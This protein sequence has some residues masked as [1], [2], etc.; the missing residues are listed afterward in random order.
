MIPCFALIIHSYHQCDP[1]H[2]LCSDQG[3]YTDASNLLQDVVSIREKSLGLDH[4]S[5]S[6]VTFEE[7]SVVPLEQYVF[8]ANHALL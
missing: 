1:P 8:F 2:T 4:P 6:H 5:V 3:K 7:F